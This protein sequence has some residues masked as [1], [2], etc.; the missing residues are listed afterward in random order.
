MK[1]LNHHL[2][3]I[4][5]M[6]IIKKQGG[7]NGVADRRAVVT[8]KGMQ[9]LLL[10]SSLLLTSYGRTAPIT[11][12]TAL[13]VAKDAL[14]N[15]EKLVIKSFAKDTNPMNRDLNVEA[16]V[17]VIGYGINSK[18]AIFAAI[19][20]INKHLDFTLIDQ[21]L[22][23][24]T[25]GIGDVKLF[26]RYTFLQRDQR[27]KTLRLAGFAGLQTPTG[28]DNK[29]DRIGRFPIPLQS[30]SG[31]L[32][33]FGGM[34]LTY[35]TLDYQI[36]GQLSYQKNSAA[37]Q[38]KVGA[39]FRADVSFQYR[40]SPAEMSSDTH[41]FIYGVIEAN[42]RDQASHQLAGLSDPTSGGSRLF[43]SPGLQYV[44]AKYILEASIQ[45]PVSQ[46]I[47]ANELAVDY[48]VTTGFRINF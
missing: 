29:T 16:L 11:F 45:L 8:I 15:R 30:G 3:P 41:R 44:T 23:R 14:V 21:R 48:V 2:L 37:N 13:P 24:T 38:F 27:S 1:F 18:L 10:V 6:P 28:K 33:Y 35:Q 12:N 19:P 22:S 36:D 42:Y 47:G 39:E 26:A 17:S 32:G 40:L 31:A 46:D 7:S 25:S 4:M 43:L 20:Y 34:I 5:K 9:I